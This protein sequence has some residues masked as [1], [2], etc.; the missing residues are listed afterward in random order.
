MAAPAPSAAPLTLSSI[1]AGNYQVAKPVVPTA[2]S[3]NN[4]FNIKVGSE[5]QQYI[6]DGSATVGSAATDGGNFLAFKDRNSAVTAAQKLLFSSGV[7]KGL[8]VDAALKKWSNNAYGGNLIPSLANTPIENLTPDQQTQ[9]LNAMETKGENDAPAPGTLSLSQIGAG[10]YNVVGKASDTPPTDQPQTS[11]M[12]SPFP[13]EQIEEGNGG[14]GVQHVEG[15]LKKILGDV[16]SAGAQNAGPVGKAMLAGAPAF[17]KDIGAAEGATEPANQEQAQGEAETSIGE[18]LVPIDKAAQVA[19]PL[20]DRQAL[21]QIVQDVSPKMSAAETASAITKQGTEKVGVLRRTV[22][23][24][25]KAVQDVANTVKQ[26]VPDFKPGGLLTD[27][28]EKVQTAV[29]K[30][31]SDLAKQ[32]ETDGKNIA[33]PIREVT[34][35]IDK[36]MQAPEVRIA[37]KG[38]QYEKSVEAFGEEVGTIMTKNGGTPSGLLKSTQEFD[39]LVKK[40]YPNLYDKDFS[41]VRSAV[42]VIRD[43]MNDT[44]DK[45]LP[46]T[47][48]QATRKIQSKL[49]TAIDNMAERAASGPDKEIGTTVI[50]RAGATI[51]KHPVLS[52]VLGTLGTLGAVQEAKKLPIIGDLIP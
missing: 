23:K 6:T 31:V 12:T 40:V 25:S 27:N 45:A 10:K 51:T 50:E 30:S 28:I 16:Y 43:A 7:Y 18:G 5:T 4:P 29:S 9:V 21:S 37:L 35:K 19:K 8:T 44:V 14:A 48:Y 1:G 17:A 15:S 24:A 41:P 13:L 52:S 22:L 42:K 49:I 20:Q 34:S 32:V 38:T 46:D 3:N 36:A 33:I 26:Y 2:G 47:A 39:G 11:Q